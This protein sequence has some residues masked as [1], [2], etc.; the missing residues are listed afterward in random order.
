MTPI[1]NLH[2]AIG[3]LAYAIAFSDGSVQREEREKFQSIVAE[4][5]ENKQFGFSL[6]DIIF[7]IMDK[8]KQ[9]TETTY[10]WA[11]KEIKTN[12][13]YL[14]PDLKQ[15]FITV[16]EKVAKA[17]PPITDEESRVLEQF[18]TDMADVHGD[19]IFYQK[20]D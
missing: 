1:E 7:Q 2:Y 14:S 5:L 17:Y 4:E 19:P 12:S 9:D 6:A 20:K 16:M 13:H 11:M 15:R 18:K 3:Q 10:Q 8:D